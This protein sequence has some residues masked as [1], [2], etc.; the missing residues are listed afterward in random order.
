MNYREINLIN[1]LLIAIPERRLPP[2]FCSR[3]EIAS[4]DKILRFL[5]LNKNKSQD[6]GNPPNYGNPNYGIYNDDAG[7]R[8]NYINIPWHKSFPENI[9]STNFYVLTSVTNKNFMF[10]VINKDTNWTIWLKFWGFVPFLITTPLFEKESKK[11]IS[12]YTYPETVIEVTGQEEGLDG[13]GNGGYNDER[14][15]MEIS[16]LISNKNYTICNGYILLLALYRKGMVREIDVI[17]ALKESYN[18]NEY[19]QY[20]FLDWETLYYGHSIPHICDFLYYYGTAQLSKNIL[21]ILIAPSPISVYNFIIPLNDH[22]IV[23]TFQSSMFPN[24]NISTWKYWEE[25]LKSS[26]LNIYF[27]DDIGDTMS[28][29]STTIL[30]PDIPGFIQG[31]LK[32]N[33]TFHWWTINHK[34]YLTQL[35]N[36]YREMLCYIFYRYSIDTNIGNNDSIGN[37]DK[38]SKGGLRGLRGHR[39]LRKLYLQ[40]ISFYGENIIYNFLVKYLLKL[41][42]NN[43]LNNGYSYYI[44][45][46]IPTPFIVDIVTRFNTHLF[47]C[48]L[49]K[50]YS[51]PINLMLSMDTHT[52]WRREIDLY[53]FI[54]LDNR[55]FCPIEKKIINRLCILYRMFGLGKNKNNIFR[56]NSENAYNIGTLIIMT[57]RSDRCRFGD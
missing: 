41:R 1:N 22:Y 33:R 28:S 23:T 19:Y 15:K 51:R 20:V 49:Y 40:I 46:D 45:S 31:I 2:L 18:P 3:D 57:L 11:Y 50:D 54:K 6:S 44:I 36:Y 10:N 55:L 52:Q 9:Y 13:N 38:G 32:N 4:P 17:N 30:I 24:F 26:I 48:D 43:L 34:K 7:N 14:F 25:S 56:I 37:N 12:K 39:K 27:N 42:L 29:D 53:S 21:D 8:F 35:R 47:N 16:Q 5:D